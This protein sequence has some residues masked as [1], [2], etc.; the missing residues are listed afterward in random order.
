MVEQLDIHSDGR[1]E[2][3]HGEVLERLTLSATDLARIKDALAK[4]IPT[5]APE[6]SLARSLELADGTV[7]TAPS[8]DAGTVTALLE[9][10]LNGH[11]LH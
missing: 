3:R 6:D 5:G 7:V 4:P 11:M 9:Q 10:L 2:M 8:P 1:V